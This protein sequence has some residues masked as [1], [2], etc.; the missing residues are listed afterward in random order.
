LKDKDI[1]SKCQEGDVEQQMARSSTTSYGASLV[2]A[3]VTSSHS[4][5]A[6][7]MSLLPTRT[8]QMSTLSTSV[9]EHEMTTPTPKATEQEQINED[10]THKS[11]NKKTE[12]IISVLIII[13]VCLSTCV[14][15][16][17]LYHT[18]K[19]SRTHRLNVRFSELNQGAIEE[20]EQGNNEESNSCETSSVDELI[21]GET[22]R[23]S[24]EMDLSSSLSGSEDKSNG[25]ADSAH[26]DGRVIVSDH[27]EDTAAIGIPSSLEDEQKNEQSN[28]LYQGKLVG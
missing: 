16:C 4:H 28:C 2:S 22:Q 24:S 3:L 11:S 6:T 19:K 17:L 26:Q 12:I 23:N 18:I 25:T 8:R 20:N 7:S 9:S 13:C 5:F 21:V 1:L 27:L 14:T 10:H 15:L